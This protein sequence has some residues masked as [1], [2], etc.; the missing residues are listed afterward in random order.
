V[1]RD[2]DDVYTDPRHDAASEWEASDRFHAEAR[3]HLRAP[4]VNH[5]WAVDGFPPTRKVPLRFDLPTAAG[6]F[7]DAFVTPGRS[8]RISLL[9][10]ASSGHASRAPALRFWRT[11]IG[12]LLAEFPGAEIVLLWAL[13]GRRTT[14]PGVTAADIAGLQQ[15]FP[16]VR[17]AY[18]VG[19]LNQL[20]DEDEAAP[21]N[22]AVDNG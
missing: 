5:R 17:N 14:T 10:A 20:A 7:A 18:D 21:A 11:L 6:A 19:L 12:A 3:R 4:V 2:W 15:D 16:E 9:F 22:P 1:P 13:R 8:P